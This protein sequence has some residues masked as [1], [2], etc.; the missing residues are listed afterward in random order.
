LAALLAELEI[1]M[2]VL[3][4]LKEEVFFDATDN[5]EYADADTAALYTDVKAS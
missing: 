2:K 5:L 4:E 3:E 1:S